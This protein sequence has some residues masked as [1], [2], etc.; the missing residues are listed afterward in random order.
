MADFDTAIAVVLVHEGGFSDDPADPGGATNF[1]ISLRFLERVRPGTT[2][3]DIRNLTVDDA[4]SLYRTYFWTLN[5]R[6]LDALTDQAV[7][8]KVLDIVVQF[9]AP[10]GVT[11]VQKTLQKLGASLAADGAYGSITESALNQFS[12]SSQPALMRELIA[13]MTL[14]Y[15]ADYTGAVRPGL[16][17]QL[18]RA[19]WYG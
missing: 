13:A 4:K 19:A 7:A 17:G 15:I 10:A 6:T 12:A 16:Y 1:G 5:A 11:E 2:A 9:G 3:A 18:R 14:R 8:T